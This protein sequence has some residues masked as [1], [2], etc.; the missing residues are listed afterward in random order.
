MAPATGR[1]FVSYR[2]QD[3]AWPASALYE[4]LVMRFGEQQ[5]FKDID[6]IKIGEDF[7]QKITEE[8]ESCD[9]LLALIGKSWLQSHEDGGLRISEPDD[10]VRLEIKTALDRAVMLIPILVDGASMP[11][12]E[13]LP[14]DIRALVRRQALALNPHGFRGGTEELLDVIEG[15]LRDRR[16]HDDLEPEPRT[17]P[18]ADEEQADTPDEN[19][20]TADLAARYL[21]ALGKRNPAHLAMMIEAY[22]DEEGSVD[23]AT[24]AGF[25]GREEED[26]MVGLTRP[27]AT[28]LKAFAAQEG[29]DPIPEMPMWPWYDGAY[30]TH[31]V[32]DEFFDAVLGDALEQVGEEELNKLAGHLWDDDGSAGGPPAVLKEWAD[33]EEDLDLAK[34]VWSKFSQRAMDVFSVFI[35]D[36]GTRHAGEKLAEDLGIPNGRYGLAGVLAWP[37][38]YCAA[39]E[40]SLP[41][42]WVE[43]GSYW[44]TAEMA[45]LFRRARDSD[46][47]DNSKEPD[48]G[49]AETRQFQVSSPRGT[50]DPLPKNWAVL[51][52]VQELVG[53]N[54]QC[55][56]IANIVGRSAFLSVVGQLDGEDLWNAIAREHGKDDQHKRLWFLDHPIHQSGRTWLLANNVW[57]PNT[58]RLFTELQTL[59]G[60]AVAAHPAGEF[61]KV[62]PRFCP[63]CGDRVE[64]EETTC[65]KCGT[66]LI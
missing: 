65:D 18:V 51:R 39:V 2:Q 43:G 24:I 1:I 63:N 12:A 32:L 55:E 14:S 29:M 30:M 37:G 34:T 4:R 13:S 49:A 52:V 44:M 17:Q 56:E 5:V 45:S 16:D 25:L 54:L 22:A 15:K 31:L 11:T 27:F 57:G 21:I 7:V 41:V 23:R 9:I 28:V 20:W 33:T 8:V 48:D 6:N 38:R 40:R 10:F 47:G 46:P 26:R 35:D 58:D 42:H 66:K 36:P 19:P 53:L 60:G 62:K 3:T 59:S 64:V 61:V 50:S